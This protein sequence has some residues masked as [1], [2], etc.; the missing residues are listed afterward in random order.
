MTLSQCVACLPRKVMFSSP[1]TCKAL[2]STLRLLGT[3][4]E[5]IFLTLS[6]H[7]GLTTTTPTTI[8]RLDFFLL[9]VFCGWPGCISIRERDTTFFF[10]TRLVFVD[11]TPTTSDGLSFCNSIVGPKVGSFF[12][13]CLVVATP[14]TTT[15]GLYLGSNKDFT[16]LTLLAQSCGP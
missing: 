2:S 10:L 8:S 4:I 6:V 12:F 15:F 11:P 7:L 14:A 3:A 16:L 9:L 1:T 5:A 13:R